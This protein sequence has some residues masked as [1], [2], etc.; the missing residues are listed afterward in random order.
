MFTCIIMLQVR[1]ERGGER[2]RE[3]KRTRERERER[4]NGFDREGFV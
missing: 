4:E 2:G 3:K 1:R